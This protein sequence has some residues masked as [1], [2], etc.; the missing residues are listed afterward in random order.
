MRPLKLSFFMLLV[1]LLLVGCSQCHN[2]NNNNNL[3]PSCHSDDLTALNGFIDSLQSPSPI[4]RS[5]VTDSACCT[6]EGVTCDSS[7]RVV[8]LQLAGKKLSGK[9]PASL[10]GLVYLKTLNLSNNFFTD[11][12]PVQLF[13]FPN[14]QLLDLSHNQFS[15]YLT[16]WDMSQNSTTLELLDLSHNDFSGEIPPGFGNCTSLHQLSLGSNLFTGNPPEDLFQLQSLTRLDL[17]AN[18]L[19]GTLNPNFSNLSNLIHLDISSNN[20]SGEIPDIFQNLKNLKMFI[21]YS[22]KFTGQLPPSLTNSPSISS[23]S[24]SNNFLS[25]SI[26]SAVN[27]SSML[28]L[29]Y[30]NLGRNY[31]V[32][33]IPDTLS[34]CRRLQVLMLSRIRLDSQIPDSFKEMTSLTT[35]SVS[36]S[37]ISNLSSALSILQHCKNLTS[38]ILTANFVNERMPIDPGLRLGNVK[39][40]V[41]ANCG[42]T[43]SIPYWL[44]HSA[45]LE[46]LDLSW[47]NLTGEIPSWFRNLEFIFYLD[48]SN[49]SLHG[50]IPENITEM[51]GLRHRNSSVKEPW[52]VELP[53]FT[54]KNHSGQSLQYNTFWSFPPT[55]DLSH[56]MLEGHI[57]TMFGN[58]RALHVFDLSHNMLSGDIP[59][60]LSKMANLEILDLSYNKL[61]GSIPFSLQQLNFLSKFDVGHNLLTGIIP[62][63][64]QFLTFPDSSFEGNSGLCMRYSSSSSCGFTRK[65]PIRNR[66]DEDGYFDVDS[67]FGLQFGLGV[68]LGFVGTLVV[69]FLI[70]RS[71]KKKKRNDFLARR[72]L[73]IQM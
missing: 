21:G 17:S 27:C 66:G 58:L 28:S 37:N 62:I 70:R 65:E 9:L 10:S 61:S 54:K 4:W 41:I 13:R 40:L 26:S 3:N 18:N 47:N 35:L 45:N 7:D 63:G 39:T 25:G 72:I 33:P 67:I 30:L 59:S 43:G 14:L 68:C 52:R 19:S 24:I 34:L 55:L 53:L 50:Q 49:N 60:D 1:T 31:F 42:L 36:K 16:T 46:L 15:G 2:N 32:G 69:K 23:L 29:T 38:L 5:S 57:S 51:R 8:G 11:S 6:W 56:N 48:L 22:N 71:P 64:G 73:N 12:V 20:F 44:S